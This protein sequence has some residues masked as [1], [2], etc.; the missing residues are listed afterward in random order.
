MDS[1]DI[2]DRL[3]IPDTLASLDQ[4]VPLELP[5]LR[6]RVDNLV[7]GVTPETR[8]ALEQR[9]SR[10]HRATVEL[11]E[12][13]DL[14]VQLEELDRLEYLVHR[15]LEYQDHLDHLEMWDSPELLDLQ[16]SRDPRVCPEQRVTRVS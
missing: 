16:V 9:D 12:R 5:D 6:V 2:P 13:L 14:W 10:V 8:V 1:R 3:D 4:P 7:I 11:Q 15:E